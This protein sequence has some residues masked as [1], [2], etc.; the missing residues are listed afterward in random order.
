MQV[1]LLSKLERQLSML[2]EE[3]APEAKSAAAS[4]AQAVFVPRASSANRWKCKEC[5]YDYNVEGK[6]SCDICGSRR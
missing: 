2:R 1:T 5:G 6:T 3:S 4:V